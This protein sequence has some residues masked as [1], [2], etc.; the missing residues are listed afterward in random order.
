MKFN[1]HILTYIYKSV[2]Y[3]FTSLKAITS[4]EVFC[5]SHTHF[6]IEKGDGDEIEMVRNREPLCQHVSHHVVHRI[7]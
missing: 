1:D 2:A 6:M 4:Q 3:K 5:L 7:A